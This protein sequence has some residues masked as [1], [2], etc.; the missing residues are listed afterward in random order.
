MITPIL[1]RTPASTKETNRSGTVERL[2]ELRDEFLVLV[3]VGLELLN[4][5]SQ[6]SDLS[7]KVR[8]L[9]VLPLEFLASVS[10]RAPC[11]VQPATRLLFKISSLFELR[12]IINR[13]TTVTVAVTAKC[14]D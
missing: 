1:I 7:L 6:Q 12:F 9:L 2:L 14:S 13:Q 11:L 3:S 5:T 8:Q 4:A 10:S